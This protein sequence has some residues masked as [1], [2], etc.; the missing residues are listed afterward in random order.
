MQS[1]LDKL[2]ILLDTGA[3]IITKQAAA[4]QLGEVQRLHPHELHH[5]LAKVSRLLKSVQWDTRIAAGNAIHSILSQ[6]P[7]WNP[8]PASNQDDFEKNANWTDTSSKLNFETFDVE[9]VVTQNL[10]VAAEETDL[11]VDS[12]I[13]KSNWTDQRD[14]SDIYSSFPV[15]DVD[16]L[17]NKHLKDDVFYFS[18]ADSNLF[19]DQSWPLSRREVNKVRRKSKN[20]KQNFS[21]AVNTKETKFSIEND[22]NISDTYCENN[23]ET[24]VKRMKIEH[25]DAKSWYDFDNGNVTD[26]R[27][28]TPDGPKSWPD[29]AIYWPFEAFVENLLQD[30]FSSKWEIRH[31]AA[32]GL[33]E[34]IKLHGKGAGKQRNQTINE[35]KESHCKWIIDA[36]LRILSVIG[37]DRFGDFVSDQ[38]IAPV[39]ETCAQ[40]FGFLVFLIPNED[41][42]QTKNNYIS[43]LLSILIKMLD[44]NA[45]EPRHGALLALKYLLIIRNDLHDDLIPRIYPVLL[46]SL[47]DPVDDVGAMAASALIPIAPSLMKHLDVKSIEDIMLNLWELIEEQDDLATAC[48]S[49][50]ELLAAITS[51]IV[52]VDSNFSFQAVRKILP[53]LWPFLH[54][55][56][57][58]VRKETLE[59]IMILTSKNGTTEFNLE[60]FYWRDYV[61]IF[62]KILHN[63]YQRVLVE[64][65]PSIQTLAEKVWKRMLSESHLDLILHATC[66]LIS[67][68]FCLCMQPHNVPYNTFVLKF[69]K[70]KKNNSNE[71]YSNENYSNEDLSDGL[72]FPSTGN[73]IYIGGIETVSET[74]RNVSVNR[75]RC[76]AARMLGLLSTYIIMP[77]PN[78]V[79]NFEDSHPCM[80]YAKIFLVHLNSKSA[81]QRM[82]IGLIM[83]QWARH[84]I[85]LP[86]LPSQLR[87][88]LLK[89]LSEYP[90]YDEIANRLYRL[91]QEYREYQ[92]LLQEHFISFPKE[93]NEDEVISTDQLL[94]LVS[95]P[96][97]FSDESK[98][99]CPLKTKIDSV[100]YKNLDEKRNLIK[101]DVLICAAQQQA[102]H[103]MTN[104]ALA[105]A[106]IRFD[107]I[108]SSP[109]PLN[110][111]IKPLMDSIKK[112]EK[113]EFQKFSAKNLAVLVKKCI[114]RKPCPNSKVRYFNF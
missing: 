64:H 21:E 82:M 108:P 91:F 98:K 70:S 52:L 37:S 97:P 56:S 80:Y 111:L 19:N 113:E 25:D 54:H 72:N 104:A 79:Q 101:N 31:G 92:S 1:R 42:S 30:L 51:S 83:T 110:P 40:V 103:I 81:I 15:S 33:R 77:A 67:T 78:I 43:N 71:N 76:A 35:M 28:V 8:T 23:E 2:F 11:D 20:S 62:Q 102:L 32:T 66:P 96:I 63:V 109:E 14:F 89:C 4:E 59:T 60:D 114:S 48:N 85:Q 99:T 47:T 86:S 24:S 105:G 18:C 69:K 3:N 34:I 22:S 112:E 50:M 7:Q 93:F 107:F 74:S 5:L 84:Q 29:S 9:K 95:S 55:A 90:H 75:A 53:R 6:V 26:P 49:F 87:D 39:R 88:R 27:C 46:K 17:N 13:V 36:T 68:W 100:T 12:S 41:S 65:I 73:V 10:L 94:V 38:V 61:T 44:S 106:V 16:K 57:S 45:W 58:N